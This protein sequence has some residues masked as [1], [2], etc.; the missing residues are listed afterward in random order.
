MGGGILAILNTY[1][2]TNLHGF[3][4]MA[5]LSMYVRIIT[6]ERSSVLLGEMI[7]DFAMI[8]EASRFI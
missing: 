4:A 1:F 8:E 3:K 2:D 6:I 5:M 7:R